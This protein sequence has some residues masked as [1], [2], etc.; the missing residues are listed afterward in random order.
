MYHVSEA[1]DYAHQQGVVHRDI[2]PANILRSGTYALI[3]DFG[4]AKALNAAMPSQGMT[5]TG[6]A[7]GTPAYMAPEQLAGDAGA[8]HRIDIYAVGL[9]AY[10][11]LNGRSPFAGTTPQR[12]LAAVLTMSPQ[13][14]KEARPDVPAGLSELVMSCLEKEPEDRPETARE[15]LAGLDGFSTAS[16]EI[17]TME[18][19]VPRVPRTPSGVSSTTT[20]PKESQPVNDRTPTGEIEAIESVQRPKRSKKMLVGGLALL[21]PVIGG[22]IFLS[23]RGGFASASGTILPDSSAVTDSA[24]VQPQVV[25]VTDSAANALVTPAVNAAANPAVIP[26]AITDS[27]KRAARAEAAKRAAAKTDSL[28]RAQAQM[29]PG[30]NARRAAGLMLADASAR[31]AFLR[32]ATRKGGP[33][34]TRRLGDLQT[35]IDALQPFLANAGLS[36]EQF[37]GIAQG[38]GVRVYDEFGRMVLDSLQRFAA[39]GR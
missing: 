8:D 4:V 5:S 27:A 19:K 14:L 24:L 7:I 29:T 17:R 34:G 22:A 30:T 23:Q 35:Q 10:E 21:I 12:I 18:R 15:L 39:G 11:L 20:P 13:P 16:G 1:L 28:K 6:M 31:S 33:L 2:K 32:G 9:L 36:Y 37:K 25:A 3:T 26:P 38:S